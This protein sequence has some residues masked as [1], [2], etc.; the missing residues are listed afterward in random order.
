MKEPTQLEWFEQ[1]QGGKTLYPLDAGHLC[2]ITANGGKTF[3][4]VSA[5]PDD[6]IAGVRAMAI[7]DATRTYEEAIAALPKPFVRRV[8]R[9]C[10]EFAP[11]LR[12]I[13]H[14]YSNVASTSN[15][16]I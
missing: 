13:D 16:P 7:A 12:E 4:C 15:V 9:A 1:Y 8:R 14:Q 2:E 3:S 5:T 6:A 11:I 10:R